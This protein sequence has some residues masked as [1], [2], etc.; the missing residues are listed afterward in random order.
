[1]F[2]VE[3]FRIPSLESDRAPMSYGEHC[4]TENY[5]Q[6][7]PGLMQ[8]NVHDV[9]KFIIFY[10]KIQYISSLVPHIHGSGRRIVG[11]A[12][13]IRYME[14]LKEYSSRLFL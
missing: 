14:C 2:S 4:D 12:F 9:D 8:I 13:E 10:F 1:M 7:V 6:K 3:S 5:N 11:T